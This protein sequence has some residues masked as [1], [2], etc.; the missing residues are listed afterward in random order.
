MS[1]VAVWITFVLFTSPEY[2]FCIVD[3]EGL[4]KECVWVIPKR[5]KNGNLSQETI[6]KLIEFTETT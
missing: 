4:T 1:M 6:D 2:P 3:K 5:D